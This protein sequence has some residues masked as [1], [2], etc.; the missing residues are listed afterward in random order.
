M[1]TREKLLSVL[2]DEYHDGSLIDASYKNNQLYVYC[3]RC[4]PNPDGTDNQETRN[5]IIR[6]DNVTE[7]EVYGVEDEEDEDADEDFFPYKEGDFVKK[8][9]YWGL[10]EIYY[11]DFEDGKVVFQWSLRFRCDDVEVLE[12]SSKQWLGN[13][14]PPL[15]F[16]K[17]R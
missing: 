9:G 13:G 14:M 6:F 17:Y 10:R 11:L 4:P 1:M 7:L 12:C 2:P 16:S 3:Y 5:I 8:E 15:D